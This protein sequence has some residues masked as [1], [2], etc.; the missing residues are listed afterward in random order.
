MK[1]PASARPPQVRLPELDGLRAIAI[2]LVLGFHTLAHVPVSWV[3]TVSAPGW[4]G[5]DLFFV[6]SGFLIGG[7]LLD[8]RAAANYYSAFYAR[9]FFRIVPLYALLVLPGLLVLALGGQAWFAG[10]SLGDQPVGALW[11]CPVFLQNVALAL[12]GKLPNYLIP[13][14][15]VAVEEQFYL[16]LPLLVRWVDGKKLT[17]LLVA[18][19]VMAPA[20]RV[21][22][23]GAFG[24]RAGDACYVLLPCRWDALLLGV[25]TALAYRSSGFRQ[26]LLGRRPW[27][28]GLWIL[29]GAASLALFWPGGSRL[30]PPLASFGYTIIDAFFATTLLLAVLGRG[31]WLQCG[32]SHPVFKP[33]ATVS[34]GLYLLHSP[35]LALVESAFHHAPI[36]YPFVGWTA[37]GV[38]LVS[39]AA[40]AVA[41]ALSWKLFESRF[42]RIGHHYRFLPPPGSAK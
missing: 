5:V 16:L 23:L 31:G 21:G 17:A 40:T 1:S 41:A 15:S 3:R 36:Y 42:I 2:L 25:I 7:I 8:H 22:L 18:A 14:W 9:R 11:S 30:A 20:L 37:T 13:T 4:V 29:L 24:E 34:Y 28:H 6:L 10:H 38:V 39:V 19:I 26:W 32:L 12:G 27:L 35:M 33:I